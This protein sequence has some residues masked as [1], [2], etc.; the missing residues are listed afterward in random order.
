MKRRSEGSDG[1]E[2]VRS[3]DRRSLADVRT[4]VIEVR[5]LKS[6]PKKPKKSSNGTDSNVLSS[7]VLNACRNSETG[8][9]DVARHEAR[10]MAR[11]ENKD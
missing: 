7:S 9:E 4:S 8:R 3:P 1:S 10:A 5:S 11:K 6:R 2:G